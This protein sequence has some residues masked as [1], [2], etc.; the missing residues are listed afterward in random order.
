MRI[1][2]T[3]DSDTTS[4]FKTNPESRSFMQKNQFFLFEHLSWHYGQYYGADQYIN[5]SNTNNQV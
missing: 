4:K 5:D 3:P 2:L 1:N